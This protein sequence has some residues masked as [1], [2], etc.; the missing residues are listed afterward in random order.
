[1]FNLNQGFLLMQKLK[2]TPTGFTLGVKAKLLKNPF[3][4]AQSY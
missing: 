1:M 2:S 4:F 3:Q